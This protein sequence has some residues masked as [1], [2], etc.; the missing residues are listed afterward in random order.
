[1]RYVQQARIL[2][3]VAA[4]AASWRDIT[5]AEKQAIVG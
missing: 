2:L 4:S 3:F 1:M 5:F